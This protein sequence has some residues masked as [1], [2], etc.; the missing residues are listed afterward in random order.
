MTNVSD[1]NAEMAATAVTQPDVSR[2]FVVL[3]QPFRLCLQ[4]LLAFLDA[5]GAV[6]S[7]NFY[8]ADAEQASGLHE[9]GTRV[10]RRKKKLGGAT[11]LFFALFLLRTGMSVR[12]ASALF[13]VSDSTGGR[14]F[15]TWL[16]FLASSLR[17]VVRLPDVGDVVPSAPPNFRRKQLSS[18]ALVFDATE[19]AVDK[20]WQSD[21]GHALWSNY[22]GKYTGKFLICI[23]PAG[24]IAFVSEGHGGHTSDTEL[25]RRS[26]IIEKLVE[27]GFGNKGMHIMADRGFNPIAPLLLAKGI[28]YVAPPSKRTGEAQFSEE[29]AGMT[30]DVANLRIHVER[31]IGAM[32][33]W[34]ILDHK[35]DSQQLD[36]LGEVALICA[37]LVNLTRKPFASVD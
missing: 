9:D 10:I 1:V 8:N 5:E 30:R 19:Y 2:M 32:R 28:H 22:K 29:D 35:F 11:G 16:D 21:A 4:N 3:Q 23:T 27:E 34:R 12:V 17:P 20:P 15:T 25:V 33:Q 24:A 7:M 18:V 13:R 6:G 37:A 14:A 36:N 26:G 31:A